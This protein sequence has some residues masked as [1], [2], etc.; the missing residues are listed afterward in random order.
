MIYYGILLGFILSTLYCFFT[1]KECIK[2]L[3]VSHILIAIVVVVFNLLSTGYNSLTESRKLYATSVA[4][5]GMQKNKDELRCSPKFIPSGV[6]IRIFS[7]NKSEKLT[8]KEIDLIANKAKIIKPLIT[9]G[10]LI[11]LFT[12][13]SDR[14]TENIKDGAVIVTHKLDVYNTIEL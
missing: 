3:L 13:S 12:T 9:V 5:C 2:T 11:L 4:L 14:T 1:R 7:G 8:T 6:Q 10:K